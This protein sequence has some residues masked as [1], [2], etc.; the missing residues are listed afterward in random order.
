MEASSAGKH[1]YGTNEEESSTGHIW[2]AGFHHIMAH[3]HLA[4]F[5]TYELFISLILNFFLGHGK[6]WITE[7]MDTESADMGHDCILLVYTQT[8]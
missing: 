2:T 6:P 8:L 1:G 4:R 5:E 7:T 3:S